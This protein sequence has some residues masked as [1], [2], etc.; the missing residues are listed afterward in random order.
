MAAADPLTVWKDGVWKAHAQY[1]DAENRFCTRAYNGTSGAQA[2]LVI[3]SA[4]G[5][6]VITDLGGND[7]PNCHDMDTSY[8]PFVENGNFVWKLY[9]SGSG[10]ASGETT[11]QSGQ[12]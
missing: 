12:F 11:W 1:N 9:W 3:D 4:G 6:V 10:S 2:T 5:R 8:I 7:D